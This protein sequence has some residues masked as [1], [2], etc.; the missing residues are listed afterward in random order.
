MHFS[1]GIDLDAKT[2][3]DAALFLSVF[4]DMQLNFLDWGRGEMLPVFMKHFLTCNLKNPSFKH[5]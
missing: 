3:G 1:D 2:G 5:F 4:F